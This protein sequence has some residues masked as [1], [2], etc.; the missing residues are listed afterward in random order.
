M[1]SSST[2]LK[3]PE[4]SVNF[5]LPCL[6]STPIPRGPFSAPSLPP[7]MCW[8]QPPTWP[9]CLPSTAQH[10]LLKCPLRCCH[11]LLK[12]VN[13]SGKSRRSVDAN[14]GLMFSGSPCMGV[15]VA[16]QSVCPW[17]WGE[18]LRKRLSGVSDPCCHQ[19]SST[20]SCLHAMALPRFSFKI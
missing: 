2:A 20:V 19:S 14:R 10:I 7:G 9:P 6:N 8:Q 17:D 18:G 4:A 11:P 12:N 1:S 15:A 5:V 13:S 3:S 16:R